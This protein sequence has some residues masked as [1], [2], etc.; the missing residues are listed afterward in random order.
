MRARLLI[1]IGLLLLLAA[2]GGPLPRLVPQSFA[3]H[4]T[5][6]MSVVGIAIPVLAA[7][8]AP[9][10]ADHPWLRSQVALPIAVS[11][12]DLVVVWGWHI[13]ALH[14][15]SRTSGWVLAVEQGIFALAA[16]LVWVSALAAPSGRRQGAALAGALTLFFT[17]MHMT[18]LGALIGLAPRPIY[19]GHAHHAPLG[20]TELAEQQLGG[21]IML[22][23]GGIIYLAGGL[24]LVGRA[25]RRPA[26]P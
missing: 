6:H 5:L 10:V 17:S 20:L 9:R 12:L 14:H 7:G 3:A 26:L 1:G 22:G 19:P 15:A 2:W 25:L 18:L 13:P 8:L 11:V 4:M 21:V 23:I 24:V 16:L